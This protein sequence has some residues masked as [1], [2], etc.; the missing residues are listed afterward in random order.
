M[1]LACSSDLL[2][3]GVSDFLC[4]GFGRVCVE[5]SMTHV[6]VLQYS[7]KCSFPSMRSWPPSIFEGFHDIVRML[8]GSLDG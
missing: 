3:A 6:S 5:L 8:S 1:S 4:E 2:R 7:E